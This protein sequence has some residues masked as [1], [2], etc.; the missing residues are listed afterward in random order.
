MRYIRNARFQRARKALL[1]AEPGEG[2]TAIAA[3]SGF[4]HLGRFSVEYRQRF[5]ESPSETLK[6]RPK[7]SH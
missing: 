4:A 3:R 7:R 2:I 6:R 1:R 5:G